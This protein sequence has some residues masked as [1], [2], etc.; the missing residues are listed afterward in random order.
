MHHP[1]SITSDQLDIR[2]IDDVRVLL[3]KKNI[4]CPGFDVM[5]VIAFDR[6]VSY[7]P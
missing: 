1:A 4:L 3:T 2:L 6:N 5:K 7:P